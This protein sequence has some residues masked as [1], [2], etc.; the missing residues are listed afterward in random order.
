ML[1]ERA[2]AIRSPTARAL[3]EALLLALD[4]GA[5]SRAARTRCNPEH[6]DGATSRRWSK[7]V[8]A[9]VVALPSFAA[10]SPTVRAAARR[11]VAFQSLSLGE[12]GGSR[13]WARA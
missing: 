6:E 12:Q 5:P 9:R 7:R 13:R 2:A 8:A 1:A 11:I 3:H 10:A 4:P